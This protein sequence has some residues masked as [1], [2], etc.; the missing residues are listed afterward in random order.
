MLSFIIGLTILFSLT[1]A[2]ATYFNLPPAKMFMVALLGCCLV[3]Y[4]FGF[5]GFMQV[6]YLLIVG[7]AVVGIVYNIISCKRSSARLLSVPMVILTIMI[8]ASILL[9]R[10]FATTDQEVREY[11]LPGLQYLLSTGRFAYESD[12]L[13]RDILHPPFLWMLQYLMF[14]WSDSIAY[15]TIFACNNLIAFACL[16]PLF[17]DERPHSRQDVLLIA[18]KFVL[19]YSLLGTGS[20]LTTLSP[21]RL[22]A[23]LFGYGIYIAVIRPGERRFE[24]TE[25]SLVLCAVMLLNSTGFA[26]AFVILYAARI[27]IFFKLKGGIIRRIVC[28]AREHFVVSVLL[29]ATSISFVLLLILSNNTSIELAFTSIVVAMTDFLY[30]FPYTLTVLA[31]LLLPNFMREK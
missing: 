10:G 3:L 6:G 15:S 16:L 20:G 2:L 30:W 22:F 23:F 18:V 24:L 28:A 26:F 21:G 4:I 27:T 12:I 17:G 11:W 5:F 31:I 25:L 9:N 29:S 19:I 13:P 8:V 7:F 14:F 1:V